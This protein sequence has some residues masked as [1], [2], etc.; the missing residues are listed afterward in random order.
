MRTTIVKGCL[1][2]GLRLPEDAEFCPECG[3]PLEEVVTRV[4]NEGH[5]L[6]TVHA[7]VCLYCGLHFPDSV[8]SC[9]KCG[10]QL[11][12]TALVCQA[13]IECWEQETHQGSASMSWS[14][15]KLEILV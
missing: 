2:C 14:Q 9:S 8:D 12:K 7:N 10:R 1:Y 5:M 11:K 3:R 15:M 13:S 4:D 6:R